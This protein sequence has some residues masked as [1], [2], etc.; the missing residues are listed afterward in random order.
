M[1]A[2]IEQGVR[3]GK[4]RRRNKVEGHPIGIIGK[5]FGCWHRQLSRP[6]YEK[7]TSYL[8]CLECGARRRFDTEEF[9]TSGPFYFPPSA[10]SVS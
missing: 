4:F 7:G 9:R 1:Q 8:T 5:I 6:F 2:V 10:A 3:G